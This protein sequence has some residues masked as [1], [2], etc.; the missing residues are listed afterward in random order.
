MSKSYEAWR[1]SFQSSEQTARFA[2]NQINEMQSE[3]DTL[4]AKVEQLRAEIN[5]IVA[6]SSGV[7]GYHLNG[8]VASWDEFELLD[9]LNKAPEQC[10]A[11][12]DAEF[13]LKGWREGGKS[14]TRADLIYYD[15]EGQD[16][17]NKIRQQTKGGE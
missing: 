4:K 3:V 6:D 14:K 2:F 15:L 13:Y 5:G 8:A 1:I 7:V 9:I 16:K 11:E 17:A 10:L 12:R